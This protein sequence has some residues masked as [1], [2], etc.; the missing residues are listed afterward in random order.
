MAGGPKAAGG[1]GLKLRI[2]EWSG[3]SG[4]DPATAEGLS[5]GTVERVSSRFGTSAIPWDFVDLIDRDPSRR[6]RLKIEQE[7]WQKMHPSDLATFWRTLR[8]RSGR[9]CHIAGRRRGAEALE[10]VEPKMQQSLTEAL[11]SSRCWDCGGDDPARRR[12]FWRN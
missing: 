2:A 4:R 6:V 5:V 10:E 1:H 9:L 3:D 8:R 7:S 12:T 11:D